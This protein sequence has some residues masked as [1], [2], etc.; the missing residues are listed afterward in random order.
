MKKITLFFTIAFLMTVCS[1]KAQITVDNST[2]KW[3]RIET[4]AALSTP[5]NFITNDANNGDGAGDGAVRV[6]GLATTPTT[7]G[8]QYALSGTALTGETLNLETVC[9]QN[10]SSL[11]N[12]VYRF[13][14]L[15]RVLNWQ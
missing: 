9:Y 12:S 11:L 10:A 3:S 7:Q 2:N 13:G 15:Q 6:K 8:V 1:L 14:M 5:A 4:G